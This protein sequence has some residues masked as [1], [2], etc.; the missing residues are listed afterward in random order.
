MTDGVISEVFFFLLYNVG[1]LGV[2]KYFKGAF[3][4]ER[5]CT[6]LV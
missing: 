3:Y 5:F 2:H 4:L 1:T 6:Q